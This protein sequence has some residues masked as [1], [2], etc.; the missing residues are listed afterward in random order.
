MKKILLIAAASLLMLA[1][2]GGSKPS[3]TEGGEKKSGGRAFT[4]NLGT[5]PASIDPQIS[6]DIA[7]G[8]VNDLIT[9]GLLK[10]DKDGKVVAGLAEKWESTEDGLVW[11]FHLRDGIK[12]SNGDP[13]TANEFRAA[14]VRAL[15]PETASEY[16]Y[17]LYPIKNGEKF[18]TGKAK[19]E[20]L[21]IKVIDE[22]TLEV[23]L[24]APTPY[25]DDLV[26]FKTYMP[27][28]EKFFEEAGEAYFTAP[29]KTLSS[30]PYVLKEWVHDSEMKFEKNP[31]YYDQASIKVDNI[32]FKLITDN[33][34]SFNAFKNDEVDATSITVAQ[35]KE[36]EKDPRLVSSNDGS[37]WY[38]LMNNK[39]DKI[40]ELG[41]AKIRRAI[42]MAVNREELTQT[43]LNGSGQPAKTLV[44][45]GIGMKGHTKADFTEEVTSV[46]PQFNVEEAKKLLEEGLKEVG[47]EKMPAIEMIFNDS[48]N[49][50]IIAEYVQE[51]LNKN[52]G[53]EL[54]LSAMTFPE[55][56]A[57]MK[58]KDFDLVL[59]GWS[60]DFHDPITYL[61]LF[62]TGGGNN[63]G[64]F[65]NARYDELVKT[66]KSTAD[67]AV[68]YPAMAELEKIIAEETP[69]GVLFHREKKYLVNPRVEGLGFR[70]IGGEYYFG[71]LSL[72]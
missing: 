8:T 19:A 71:N 20:D 59:A 65:S 22:K 66:I 15:D 32:V 44:P 23:T 28:N 7:G 34:A 13:I 31:N 70:A 48:G 67:P 51:S 69:V 41:N 57:R 56:V 49:N 54:Q 26:T 43:V 36:F 14:W 72:K 33:A 2:G 9:E 27:L 1:C 30:G 46:I 47:S 24:E 40:K 37:V 12:W 6:T 11:T 60:G 52:L 5:E 50:K 42:L 21:G 18:N 68:R 35:A 64:S 53:I 39:S 17:M 61:D 29:D 58:Q 10:T 55:R 63:H 3:G 45:A 25:F 16:S 4:L 62:V 38:L